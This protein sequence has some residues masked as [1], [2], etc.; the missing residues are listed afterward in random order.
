MPVLPSPGYEA[1]ASRI[2]SA[3]VT[4]WSSRKAL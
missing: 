1:D 4:I 3:M 2:A